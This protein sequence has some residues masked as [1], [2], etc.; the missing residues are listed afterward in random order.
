MPSIDS[1][2][3]ATL[4]SNSLS[5]RSRSCL[6]VTN[7]PSRPAKGEVLTPKVIFIV[8]GSISTGGSLI[9]FCVLVIVSPMCTSSNPAMATM[10]PATASSLSTCF[11]PSYICKALILP[12][13]FS[14]PWALIKIAGWACLTEPEVIL[15]MPKR[16]L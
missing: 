14:S 10:S 8:G 7:L 6:E 13:N 12:G 11:K 16:P 9:G 15:P 3:S 5:K 2:L 4:V 1:I